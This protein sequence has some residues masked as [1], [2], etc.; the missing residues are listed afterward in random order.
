MPKDK[1]EKEETYRII[2]QYI[3]QLNALEDYV[4]SINE[5]LTDKEKRMFIKNKTVLKSFQASYLIGFLNKHKEEFK[6]VYDLNA[7]KDDSLSLKEMGDILDCFL[8]PEII[9][10]KISESEI[11]RVHK[12]KINNSDKS[13]GAEESHNKPEKGTIIVNDILEYFSITVNEESNFVL[14]IT[15]G[16]NRNILLEHFENFTKNSKHLEQL[17]TSSVITLANNFELLVSRIF[18][19]YLNSN[20]ED[21]DF[22]LKNR[23]IDFGAL[24]KI[25]NVEEAKELLLEEYV[26]SLM[27]DSAKTWLIKLGKIN[28]KIFALDS[29]KDIIV[30]FY[31][32]RNIIVHNDGIINTYYCNNVRK[33]LRDGLSKGDRVKVTQN[34]ISQKIDEFKEAGLMIFW[35]IYQNLYKGTTEELLETY[36]EFAFDL[37]KTGNYKLSRTIYNLILDDGDDK[38]ISA[39]T[40]LVCKI[41]LWQTYKWNEEFSKVKKDV[42]KYDFSLADSELKMARAILLDN[43]SEALEHLKNRMKQLEDNE[44][45]TSVIDKYFN[46]PLFKEFIIFDDFKSYLE[47]IGYKIELKRE[48]MEVE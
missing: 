36:Q 38:N 24:T 5:M 15:S 30:E 14:L 23:T 12:Y 7:H 1:I 35:Y 25:Q 31:Q 34:Y 43:Y 6:E 18:S 39:M 26:T 27:K 37:L 16:E 10:E 22:D 20:S 32:R 46:W 3:Q 4:D 48:T 40:K 45:E 11:K 21:K 8:S 19:K 9:S 41:N 29:S 47:D 2:I 42:E 44:T 13:E 17:Y 28:K 33:E